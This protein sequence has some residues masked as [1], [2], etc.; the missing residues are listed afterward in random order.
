M[1]RLKLF[2]K[3]WPRST[4]LF[5]RVEGWT[6]SFLSLFPPPPTFYI[7]SK[8][9]LL[10][11]LGGDA[12]APSMTQMR[13]WKHSTAVAIA[14]IFCF[15]CENVHKLSQVMTFCTSAHTDWVENLTVEKIRSTAGPTETC[16]GRMCVCVPR[17]SEPQEHPLA[18]LGEPFCLCAPNRPTSNESWTSSSCAFYWLCLLSPS[19]WSW[20]ERNTANYPSRMRIRQKSLSMTG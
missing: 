20:L 2:G 13:I 9:Y 19:P 10:Q 3:C 18:G 11:L 15:S 7:L 1:P 17:P 8:K 6:H 5:L 4:L 16:W 14:S 12:T